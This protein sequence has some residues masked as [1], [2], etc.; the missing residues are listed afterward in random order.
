MSAIEHIRREVRQLI[1]INE[2]IQ[3]DLARGGRLTDD[4]AA[5][6]RMCAVELLQAIRSATQVID[7]DGHSQT[8]NVK[9]G[10]ERFSNPVNP[11]HTESLPG[12][13]EQ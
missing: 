8:R 10:D 13:A 11:M 1:S 7:G 5:V 9:S 12:G 4:E 3:S 6:V 2:T